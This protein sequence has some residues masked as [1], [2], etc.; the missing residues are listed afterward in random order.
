MYLA[1]EDEGEVV[2][3]FIKV[4]GGRDGFEYLRF[5]YWLGVGERVVW[6]VR[7]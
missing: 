3:V 6:I 1:E 4:F 5:I 2:E 7:E